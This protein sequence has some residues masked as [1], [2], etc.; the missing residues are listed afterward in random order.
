MII[1]LRIVRFRRVCRSGRLALW[2]IRS[3]FRGC[4]N[5]GS[6]GGERLFVR[7]GRPLGAEAGVPIGFTMRA[8]SLRRKNDAGYATRLRSFDKFIVE[9]FQASLKNPDGL[10]TFAARNKNTA[11]RSCL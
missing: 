8:D 3:A 6:S 5:F 9:I 7:D 1:I 2:G 10:R 4:R 11:F